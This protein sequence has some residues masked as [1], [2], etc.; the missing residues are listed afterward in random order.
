M[1]LNFTESAQLMKVQSVGDFI[2][3]VQEVSKHWK[4]RDR[5][6]RPWFRGESGN[7]DQLLPKIAK[8]GHTRD[9]ENYLLQSFR[10]RAGGF[11]NT[12][13]RKGHTDLWLFLAQHYGMPTHLL[14]WSEGALLGLFFAI[15][16][17]N[18]TNR[19]VYMLNPHKLN[20]LA[21][22]MQLDELNYPLT[23]TL[24]SPAYHNIRLAWEMRN[25]TCGLDLPIAIAATY[26]D[27]RMIAQRSCFTIHGKQLESIH[28]LIN[29]KRQVSDVHTF[30]NLEDILCKYEIEDGAS[31]RLLEELAMLGV[32]GSTI[33][34]DLDHLARDIASELPRRIPSP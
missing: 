12:P 25:P 3:K 34:P 16:D 19:R 4:L 30:Q 14:D 2:A 17:E 6:I 5:P 13:P 24:Q 9:E 20:T 21:T 23:W 27:H 15:S 32:T 11:V 29:R 22:D 28:V 18:K 7:E 10:R 33:F 26:Q 1:P 8:Y 31:K